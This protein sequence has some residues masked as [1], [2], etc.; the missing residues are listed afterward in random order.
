MTKARA[1]TGGSTAA[2]GSDAIALLLRE[3]GI[4]YLTLCPGSSVRGLHDSF[5]NLLG[6]ERPTPLV[7][8]HEEH[9]VA[10]AHGYAKVTG[11]P[12]VAVIHT[13]VGLLHA[14]MAIYNAWCDRAPVVVIAGSGPLDP[15]A[16]KPWIDWIHAP[17]DPVRPVGGFV[18]SASVPRSV[19]DAL[20]AVAH[21]LADAR[22]HPQGPT[23][24]CLET[25]VQEAALDAPRPTRVQPRNPASRKATGSEIS[26]ATRL[27]AAARRPVILAGRVARDEGSWMLRVRLAERLKARVITDI[28]AGA[29]FPTDH[30]LHVPGTGFFLSAEARATLA[31]ADCILSLDWIDLAGTLAQAG[32]SSD[33]P[34]LIAAGPGADPERPDPQGIYGAVTVDVAVDASPDD[35]VPALLEALDPVG[36]SRTQPIPSTWAGRVRSAANETA[37]AGTERLTLG[38]LVD[39]LWRATDRTPVCLTRVPIGWPTDQWPLRHP[40][41]YIGYDGGAGIGSGPGMAIGSALALRGTGRLAV[42]VLGDGDLLMG[43][44]ALWTA[45][46]CRIPLLIVVANNR[47]YLSDVAQQ[48]QVAIQRMRD[49]GNRWV[50]QT[51]DD[52]PVDIAALARAQG[53]AAWGPART[54]VEFAACLREAVRAALAGGPALVDALVDVAD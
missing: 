17:D 51:I 48:E 36:A 39:G 29:A 44:S 18:K 10:I 34:T 32:V 3:E 19:P 49:P 15:D 9:A 22:A 23:L 41:D 53:L 21:A 14:S 6:N 8:L 26:L 12:L 30:P 46:R 40:L 16:R 5:V 33:P 38:S 27:L 28:K 24:V 47:A 37:E 7:C 25:P 35:A 2:W 54:T 13:N 11:E 4:P 45:A 52:P 43:M 50:G 42:A 31:G 1:D 20:K